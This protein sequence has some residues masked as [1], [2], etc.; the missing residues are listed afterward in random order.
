MVS[1]IAGIVLVIVA[2]ILWL[3]NITVPH[4][5]AILIGVIGVLCILGGFVPG[6]YFRRD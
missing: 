2:V 3:G 6:H 5:L 1:V 4:A